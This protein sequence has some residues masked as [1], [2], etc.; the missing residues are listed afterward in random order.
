M[1]IQ[2]L[3]L[4]AFMILAPAPARAEANPLKFHCHMDDL[5]GDANQYG[6]LDFERA[7]TRCESGVCLV[8]IDHLRTKYN[9]RD[10]AASYNVSRAPAGEEPSLDVT[11]WAYCGASPDP[12]RPKS[13]TISL[14][15][16]S[17]H[18]GILA[19]WDGFIT[20]IRCDRE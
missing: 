13:Q 4:A 20:D 6:S 2:L 18:F 17:R 11:L 1:K 14:P 15:L 16:S 10:I 12:D 9:C 8:P 5:N 19:E 7:V 3:A